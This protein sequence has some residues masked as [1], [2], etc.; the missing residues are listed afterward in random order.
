RQIKALTSENNQHLNDLKTR[1]RTLQRMTGEMQKLQKDLEDAPALVQLRQDFRTLAAKLSGT[2]TTDQTV[3]AAANGSAPITSPSFP[4]E[5]EV[6][7]V[8]SSP[9]TTEDANGSTVPATEDTATE[10]KSTAGAEPRATLRSTEIAN[11]AE[12]LVG[13]IVA[14]SRSDVPIEADDVDAAPAAEQTEGTPTTDSAPETKP[15][16]QKKE[17][18][19]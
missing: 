7:P 10:I 13:R 6:Q 12:A 1:D 17:L 5:K 8:T 2:D 14:S 16:K 9:N 11:A 3:P 19:A 15:S 18:M 4:D